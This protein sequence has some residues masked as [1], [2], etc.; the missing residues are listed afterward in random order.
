MKIESTA[1]AEID[2]DAIRGNL[3]LAR[4]MSGGA[5]VYVVCKGHAYGFDAVTAAKLAVAE[6]MDAL[7]CGGVEDVRRIRDAGV[8][9]PILLYATTAAGDLP[10]IASLGVIVTAHDRDSL[11]VC[12]ANNLLF[13]IKLDTGFS[14]LGFQ[15]EALDAVEDAAR[16]YPAAR[17][18]GIYTHL[19]GHD[20]TAALLRQVGLFY[21]MSARV[22][23]AGWNKLERM[24]ASTRVMISHPD[25]VLD[26]VNPGRLIYGVLEKP[27]DT[28]V[29]ARCAL[30]AVKAKIIALKQV[31]A[32]SCL[33]YSDDVLT[34]DTTLAVIPFGFAN[35]YPRLPSGGEALLRGQRARL[36]GPRHTEHSILDVTEI[37]GASLGDEVVLVGRQGKEHIDIHEVS[38]ATGVPLIELVARLASSFQKKFIG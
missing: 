9:L 11:D 19:S 27:Y 36:L 3:R 8:D 15:P 25:L 17:A 7:A 2:L 30:A 18:F 12:L 33:G 38:A 21:S 5:R 14:R 34:R 26:A 23:A 32:G 4:A 1:W 37:A 20:D 28:L 29:E 31:K 13:S 6:K 10:K 24:V 22:Q 16:R 35:G